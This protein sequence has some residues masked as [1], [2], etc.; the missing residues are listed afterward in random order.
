[1]EVLGRRARAVELREDV[2]T[3]GPSI[4]HRHLGVALEPPHA[5]PSERL[6]VRAHAVPA[7]QLVDDRV[8]QAV[9]VWWDLLDDGAREN[10][11]DV[12][13]KQW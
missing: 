13:P 4:G 10:E 3:K 5:V 11:L 2:H 1:M 6:R 9:T 8:E 7:K 12:R